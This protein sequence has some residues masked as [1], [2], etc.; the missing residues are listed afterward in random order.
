MGIPPFYRSEEFREV[1]GAPGKF[2]RGMD[3][4][5]QHQ[6][7]G[8]NIPETAVDGAMKKGRQRPRREPLKSGQ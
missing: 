6:T 3:I 5:A 7:W 2:P 8:R 4:N 1:V